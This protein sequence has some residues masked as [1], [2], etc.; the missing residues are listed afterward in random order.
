MTTEAKPGIAI[1]AKDV[2]LTNP[3]GILSTYANDVGVSMT[4]SD[5]R[6]LFNEVGPQIAGDAGKG[7]KILKANVVIPIQMA[8][9]LAHGMLA[10]IQGHKKIVEVRA[11]VEQPQKT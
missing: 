3:L 10:A 2:P 7:E 5:F 1:E 11:N 8:E 4:L 6:I 9:A